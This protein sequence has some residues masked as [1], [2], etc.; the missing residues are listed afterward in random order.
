MLED[1]DWRL[2][3]S[4]QYFAESMSKAVKGEL[5]PKSSL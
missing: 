1:L 3:A 5:K 2:P 4:V